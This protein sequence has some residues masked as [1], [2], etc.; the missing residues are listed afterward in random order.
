MDLGYYEQDKTGQ[1]RRVLHAKLKDMQ[2]SY[3]DGMLCFR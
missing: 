1:H 2:D 3:V